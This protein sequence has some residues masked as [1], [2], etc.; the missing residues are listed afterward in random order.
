LALLYKDIFKNRN[1]KLG[2]LKHDAHQFEID[3]EG[4]DSWRFAN[5]GADNVVISSKNKL[6]MIKKVQMEEKIEDTMFLFDDVDLVLMEGFRDNPYDKIEVHRKEVDDMLVFN[7][8]NYA[9]ETFIALATNEKIDGILNFD[10]NDVI[11]IADFIEYRMWIR[12][13]R[14]LKERNKVLPFKP[15]LIS[16]DGIVNSI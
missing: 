16:R 15:L 3:K 14:F 12:E 1:Y 5:A 2:A 6:A 9:R 10:I 7:N 13:E 8:K 4:K 11:A